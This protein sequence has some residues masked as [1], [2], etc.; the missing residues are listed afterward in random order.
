MKCTATGAHYTVF[1]YNGKQVRDNIHSA[2]L[3]SAFR[4]YVAA[5]RPGEVYNIGGSRHSH[6]SMLEA[7]SLCEEISG[8]ELDREY[9]EDNRVGLRLKPLNVVNETFRSNET[10]RVWKRPPHGGHNE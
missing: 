1:G 3:V 8:R 9:V 7:I 10:G 6:C 5:P 2:D 4:E